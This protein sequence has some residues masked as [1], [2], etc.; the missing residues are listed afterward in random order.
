VGLRREDGDMTTLQISW[1]NIRDSCDLDPVEYAMKK[2]MFEREYLEL[3]EPAGI[4]QLFDG[5]NKARFSK[6]NEFRLNIAKL[7]NGRKG[8][9]GS[10]DLKEF[11]E[12]WLT[13]PTRRTHHSIDFCPKTMKSGRLYTKEG[14]RDQNTTI[15][16]T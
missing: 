16:G 13:D 6:T 8:S 4:V 7:K 2:A 11:F 3:K 12:V 9:A 15:E 14:Q 1:V 5:G 10:R